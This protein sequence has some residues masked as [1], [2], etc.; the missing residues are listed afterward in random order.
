MAEKQSGAAK[1]PHQAMYCQ[2][3][4][5][6][7]QQISGVAMGTA[8][9]LRYGSSDADITDMATWRKLQPH[10]SS[11][12]WLGVHRSAVFG[13]NRQMLRKQGSQSA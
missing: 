1:G 10:G 12:T 8:C 9:A 7:Y 2:K 6:T 13:R 11:D 3:D 5:I 4:G